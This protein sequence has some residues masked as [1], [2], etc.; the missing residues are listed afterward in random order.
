[1][2]PF[3][4]GWQSLKSITKQPVMNMMLLVFPV[5]KIKES[6]REDLV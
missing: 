2:A 5:L 4:L 1:M 3:L 6:E